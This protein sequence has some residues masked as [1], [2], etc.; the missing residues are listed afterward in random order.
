M[1]VKFKFSKL[2]FCHLS[3]ETL[4]FYNIS[5][6]SFYEIFFFS[7]ACTIS[8]KSLSFSVF[9]LISGISCPCLVNYLFLDPPQNPIF[10]QV[11]TYS[12]LYHLSISCTI[13][14]FNLNFLVNRITQ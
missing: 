1:H 5:H 2:I 3:I 10:I 14:H 4:V 12:I 13:S 6:K 9:N 7:F 8:L 11:T